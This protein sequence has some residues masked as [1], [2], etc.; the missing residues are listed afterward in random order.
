MRVRPDHAEEDP[1]HPHRTRIPHRHLEG[2]AV[3]TMT[4]VVTVVAST[5]LMTR[6]TNT[7]LP[8]GHATRK[9]KIVVAM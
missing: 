2:P 5:I 6:T 9:A 4:D 7:T 1:T 8:G 3:V